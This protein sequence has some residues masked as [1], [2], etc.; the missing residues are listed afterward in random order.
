MSDLRNL[1]RLQR[2]RGLVNN[3]SLQRDVI[4]EFEMKDQATI[5]FSQG[6]VTQHSYSFSDTP[7]V[8]GSDLVA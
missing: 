5:H 2:R 4:F 8:Y 6:V 7:F 3:E 1:R